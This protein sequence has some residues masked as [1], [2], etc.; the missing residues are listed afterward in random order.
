MFGCSRRAA[1]RASFKNISLQLRA[2]GEV[3]EDALERDDL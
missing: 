2:V 3:R 1:M